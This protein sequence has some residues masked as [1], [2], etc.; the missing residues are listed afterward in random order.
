MVVL[1]N[2]QFRI[3]GLIRQSDLVNAEIRGRG[4]SQ[5]IGHLVRRLERQ[6]LPRSSMLTSMCHELTHDRQTSKSRDGRN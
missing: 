1:R 3:A 5:Q 4:S 6:H 2:E